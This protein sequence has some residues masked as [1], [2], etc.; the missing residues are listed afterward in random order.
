MD[1]CGEAR[2]GINEACDERRLVLPETGHLADCSSCHAEVDA[3][4]GLEKLL[5]GEPP[6][7]PPTD[8][9]RSVMALVRADLARAR[10][11]ARLALAGAIAALV[12]AAFGI[13]FFDVVNG[14]RGLV[15]DTVALAQ[16]GRALV[17]SLPSL[18]NLELS[19]LGVAYGS[20]LLVA[21]VCAVA[22]E[23]RLLSRRVAA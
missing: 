15:Q 11:N 22:L 9:R 1:A 21:T 6:V 8:L 2:R 7:D 14:I 5:A 19:S 18:P 4:L 10:R 12:A 17:P 23:V 16:E 13:G 20:A 3:L